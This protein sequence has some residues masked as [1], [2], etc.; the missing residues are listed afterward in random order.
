MRLGPYTTWPALLA[1]AVL[2]AG[3]GPGSFHHPPE[4]PSPERAEFELIFDQ[5]KPLLTEIR[6]VRKQHALAESDLRPELEKRYDELV[7]KGHFLEAQLIDAAV[8]A[9]VKEP[10]ENEDLAG[11]LMTMTGNLLAKEQYEECLRMAQII[12]DN[13]VGEQIPGFYFTYFQAAIAAF[14]AGEFEIAEK[15]FELLDQ[16]EFRIPGKDTLAQRDPMKAVVRACKAELPYYREAWKREE[17]LRE[18]E[19]IAGDLPR[20]RLSTTKGDIE[21][22]LFENEAPN[23]VANFIS[24]VEKEFY[25]GLTFHNVKSR[26]G[27]Q[28]R[29]PK[30]DGSGHP[31]YLI[32]CECYQQNRRLHFRGSLSMM[33]AGPDTG[34]SQFRILF[35]PMRELD[36]RHTVFGRVTRGMDVLSRLRIR[37]PNPNI[38]KELL[39]KAD[40]ILRAEVL[41]KRSHSYEPKIIP[42]EKPDEMDTQILEAEF[43][44]GFTTF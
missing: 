42:I 22:E 28:T 33:T 21:V 9:C 14:A 12:I 43:P 13:R 1:A 29:C 44:E 26:L 35:R 10:E 20:V 8:I 15:H 39:P 34:G 27:A 40:E 24:L 16:K 31:G 18:Q 6:Q 17:E 3:C 30:A 32:R 23:T 36:G 7:E 11:F 37:E 25:D 38:P 4:D 41:R 2:S 19:K 5:W